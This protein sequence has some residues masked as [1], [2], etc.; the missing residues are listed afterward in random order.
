MNDSILQP[1]YRSWLV[2]L[3]STIKQSQIKA[4][5]SVNSELIRLY[6][7]MGRQIVEKQ[8]NTSWG[9]GFIDQLSRDLK[10]EF[11]EMKGFSRSNLFA[12]K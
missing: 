3:K 8:Q 12:I 7:D 4:A 5:L 10:E 1:D 6:W 2:E 9:S 11:P